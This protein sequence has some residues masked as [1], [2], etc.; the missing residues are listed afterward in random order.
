MNNPGLERYL[1]SII[2]PT[3]CIIR[4][5]TAVAIIEKIKKSNI[6]LLIFLA[7]ALSYKTGELRLVMLSFIFIE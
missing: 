7:I 4:M 3:Y 2:D 5:K 1:F 6:L